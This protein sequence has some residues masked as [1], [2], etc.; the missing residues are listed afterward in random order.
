MIAPSAA[1]HSYLMLRSIVRLHRARP[2]NTRGDALA[3]NVSKGDT[4]SVAFEGVV[5]CLTGGGLMDVNATY[6]GTCYHVQD[7]PVGKATVTK[8]APPA[9]PAMGTV[10]DYYGDK[11][12]RVSEGW[13]Y[14]SVR[15]GATL[16]SV[17][18]WASFDHR[19]VRVL[20]AGEPLVKR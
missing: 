15:K 9:Q 8:P 13:I 12:A 4:V 16:L 18:P 19:E 3:T 2:T 10:I 17:S 7:I 6:A 1:T 20:T 5:E 11:W 14:L